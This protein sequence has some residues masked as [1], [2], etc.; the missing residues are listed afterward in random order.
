[1]GPANQVVAFVLAQFRINVTIVYQLCGQ[2]GD[3]QRHSRNVLA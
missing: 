1:M 2:L 3:W